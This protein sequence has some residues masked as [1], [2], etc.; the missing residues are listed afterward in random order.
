[1]K[2]TKSVACPFCNAPKTPNMSA[3]YD[4]AN[5]DGFC[6]EC[7]NTGWINIEVEDEENRG[8]TR[9]N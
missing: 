9:G 1:M 4:W 6:S 8:A 7:K 5:D 3:W 2:K